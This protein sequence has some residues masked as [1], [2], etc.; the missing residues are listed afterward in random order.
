MPEPRPTERANGTSRALWLLLATT[1]AIRALA[2]L[3]PSRY[4]WGVDLAH[5]LPPVTFWIPWLATAALLI[6]AISRPLAKALP[7]SPRGIALTG[8]ALAAAMAALAWR[9]PDVIQFTGDSGMRHGAFTTADHPLLLVPQAMPGDLWLHWAL[10]RWLDARIGWPADRTDRVLGAGLALL[11]GVAAWRLARAAGLR[12]GAALAVMAVAGWTANLALFS[13]YA[14]SLVELAVIELAAAAALVGVLRG[15]R[16]LAAL[17]LLTAAALVMHRAGLLLLPAWLAG[18]GVALTRPREAR[19][20]WPALLACALPPLAT[21]AWLGRRLAGTLAHFDVAHHVTHDGAQ[22]SRIATQLFGASHLRDAA[23]LLLLLVP[24]LPLA[25]ALLFDRGPSGRPEGDPSTL[26]KSHLAF[27]ALVLPPLLL[28]LL[29]RPQQGLFRDWDVFAITGAAVAA[30]LATRLGGVLARERGAA[31]LA[32]PLLLASAAPSAQ[33]LF[34]Q[35]DPDRAL[36]RARALLLGP[37]LRSGDERATGFDRLSLLYLYRGDAERMAE[38]C[39]LS[40]DAAPNP[41]VLA[42]WGMAETLRQ[43]YDAAQAHY[44]R[45]ASLNPGFT[46][47]WKGVAASSSALGDVPHMQQAVQALRVLEPGGAT[48]RDASEWLERNRPAGRD[49]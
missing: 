35:S 2:P 27:A 37:P 48:V 46:M 15:G 43:R 12:G 47:A 18:L 36:P 42:E 13:G 44:L 10:P 8:L 23:N 14:K 39:S 20:R 21:L 45:A 1:L 32:L 7:E 40:V 6:P 16:G 41:R 3:I 49:Q 24:V 5:D 22:A 33:W 9:F 31:W 38:A 11:N 28:L 19:P 34:H 25:L 29:V 4:V 26:P 17:G 30:W